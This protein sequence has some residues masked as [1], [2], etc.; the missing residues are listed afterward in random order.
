MLNLDKVSFSY[1]K[2]EVLKDFSLTVPD[3]KCVVLGAESGRGKTTVLRLL[4]RLEKPNNGS[5]TAPEKI[6]V[7]FQEDRLAE[8]L[9]VL[10]NVMLCIDETRKDTAIKLLSEAGLGE[11]IYSKIKT[12]SGGMKRRVAIVRAVAYS[13]DALL[14][15]EPFNG[16]DY[17]TKKTMAN[18][19]KREFLDKNKPVFLISHVSEDAEL[20][21]AVHKKI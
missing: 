12:L 17:E 13:G 7:V 1:G 2:K 16:L 10:N 4:S 19:I 11:V 21:G 20:L 8:N 3:G 6:S 15:D 9:N 14:L 5:V 18:M